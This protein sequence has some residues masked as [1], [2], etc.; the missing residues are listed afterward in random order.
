MIDLVRSY[1]LLSAWYHLLR[2]LILKQTETEYKKHLSWN[3]CI[4][5]SFSINKYIMCEFDKNQ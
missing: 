4:L 3:I 5:A 1:V 2:Q